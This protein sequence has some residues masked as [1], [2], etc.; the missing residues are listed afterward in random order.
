MA[1]TKSPA[2]SMLFTAA[3]SRHAGLL[4]WVLSRVE[5]AWGPVVLKS[6]KFDHEETAYYQSSM[7]S[8]LKKQFFVVG[9]RYDPSRLVATKLESNGWEKEIQ[10]AGEYAEQRPVNVDPGY[11]T[12]DKLILASAK[13]RAHRVYLHDGIYA[14]QCLYY[15]QRA[16]CARPWTYPD[17]MQP[18]VLAFFEQA[19]EQLKALLRDEVTTV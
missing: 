19:R 17:Y 11:F 9:G 16:W 14:E 15:Q 12:L 5:E 6:Q 18:G 13:D 7:G 2:P 3:F 10:A 8:D 4:D 1:H